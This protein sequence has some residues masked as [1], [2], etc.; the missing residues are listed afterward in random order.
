M[1][2]PCIFRK[3]NRSPPQVMLKKEVHRCSASRWRETVL[4]LLK[5]RIRKH[6]PKSS[7]SSRYNAS[8]VYNEG[9]ATRCLWILNMHRWGM[10]GSVNVCRLPLFLNNPLGTPTS[11]SVEIIM[12]SVRPPLKV[13]EFLCEMVFC[14]E[15]CVRA[16]CIQGSDYVSLLSVFHVFGLL[17]RM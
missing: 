2:L 14:F 1:T 5:R 17:A 4:L 6:A 13:F 11:C 15:V 7:E 8:Y 3:C 9:R 16:K 12:G 10:H